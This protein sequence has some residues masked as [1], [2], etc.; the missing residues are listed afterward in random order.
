MRIDLSFWRLVILVD[1]AKSWIW[2]KGD[3]TYFFHV[4]TFT[5]GKRTAVR[6]I[7]L[8]CSIAVGFAR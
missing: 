2:A 5:N 3:D 4:G 6:I 8:P 7:F 1:F